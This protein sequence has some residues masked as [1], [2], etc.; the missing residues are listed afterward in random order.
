MWLNYWPS[1][2]SQ[3]GKHTPVEHTK[4]ICS[5]RKQ[6]GGEGVYRPWPWWSTFCGIHIL[7]LTKNFPY[8]KC[9]LQNFLYFMFMCVYLYVCVSHVCLH[10]SCIS[11]KLPKNNQFEPDGALCRPIYSEDRGIIWAQEFKA[12][13]DNKKSACASS[14]HKGLVWME[15]NGTEELGLTRLSVLQL[16]SWL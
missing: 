13:L 2:R 9:S 5:G 10:V 4:A 1:A 14:P 7:Q 16:K 15:E 12:S 8:N 6:L 3:T 11:I